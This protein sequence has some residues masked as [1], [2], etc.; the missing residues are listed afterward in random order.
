MMALLMTSLAGVHHRM[1]VGT[2]A[3]KAAGDTS[4]WPR[5][6]DTTGMVRAHSKSEEEEEEKEEPGALRG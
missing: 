1:Q 5:I 4:P 6:W 2:S 3:A